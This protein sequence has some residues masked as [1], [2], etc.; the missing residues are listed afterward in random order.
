MIKRSFQIFISKISR[1]LENFLPAGTTVNCQPVWQT[2]QL[3]KRVSVLPVYSVRSHLSYCQ[4]YAI[5]CYSREPVTHS[6]G[7]TPSNQYLQYIYIIYTS[8]RIL[9]VRLSRVTYNHIHSYP[10]RVVFI[11]SQLKSIKIWFMIQNLSI[12]YFTSIYLLFAY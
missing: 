10:N 11:I 3:S 6:N 12:S 4:V 2:V 9:K 8:S 7:D 1:Y 5:L